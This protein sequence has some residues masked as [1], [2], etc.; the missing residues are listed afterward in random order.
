MSLSLTL[1]DVDFDVEQ[2][3][4]IGTDVEMDRALSLGWLAGCGWT[5]AI[6]KQASK[7]GSIEV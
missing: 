4:T 2:F 3:S 6:P 5:A 7:H 1:V